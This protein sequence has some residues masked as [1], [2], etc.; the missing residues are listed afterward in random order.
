MRDARRPTSLCLGRWQQTK[1]R[2]NRQNTN[3]N[4]KQ[5]KRQTHTKKQQQKTHK[6]Q[7]FGF[8]ALE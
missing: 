1:K 8:L 3:N 7:T 4:N 5:T 2:D 6:T